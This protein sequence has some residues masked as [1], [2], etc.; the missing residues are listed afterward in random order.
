MRRRETIMEG[1]PSQ[2]RHRTGNPARRRCC[3]M[4]SNPIPSAMARRG[5]PI[6]AGSGFE[7][8]LDVDSSCGFDSHPLRHGPVVQRQEHRS[9]KPEIQVR[10]LAGLPAR[11]RGE[12]AV[13]CRTANPVTRV[14]VPPVPPWGR[15]S[16]GRALALQARGC[17]FD[18]RR[19][20]H[21]TRSSTVEHRTFNPGM[22]VRFSPGLP[23]TDG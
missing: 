22:R 16:I 8:R 17:G 21:R 10:I 20:H 9:P 15:S 5:Q 14:Q 2:V 11:R 18:P 13:I 3:Y 1:W 4:G 23:T 19:F 7:N 6:G 12:R